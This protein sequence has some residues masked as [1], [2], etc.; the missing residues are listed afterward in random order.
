MEPPAWRDAAAIV[1]ANIAG[2]KAAM[3]PAVRPIDVRRD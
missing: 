2:V 1:S 3:R